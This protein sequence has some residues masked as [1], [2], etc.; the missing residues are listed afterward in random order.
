[1]FALIIYNAEFASVLIES[2]LF[3]STDNITH[4]PFNIEAWWKSRAKNLNI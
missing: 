2:A 3:F 1:M 4:S